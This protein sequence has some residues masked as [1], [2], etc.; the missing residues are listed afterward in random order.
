MVTSTELNHNTLRGPKMSC[1]VSQ[2][3]QDDHV[4]YSDGRPQTCESQPY[5]RARSLR[6]R[7]LQEALLFLLQNAEI[8]PGR[9]TATPDAAFI[10]SSETEISPFCEHR[11]LFKGNQT[12]RQA[13]N[14]H[15][16]QEAPTRTVTR[17]VMASDFDV[18]L[19]L[20]VK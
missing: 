1:R 16:G 10:G 15:A 18:A 12:D 14:A 5:T 9:S 6:S 3:T 7:A 11:S 17:S 19:A 8:E 13:S 20:H 2:H 4:V